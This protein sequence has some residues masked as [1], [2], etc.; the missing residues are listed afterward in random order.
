M[1]L[2]VSIAL[3][4]YNKAINYSRESVYMWQQEMK[5][6]TCREEKTEVTP[7]L[8]AEQVGSGSLPVYATPAL[9]ALWEKAAAGLLM[10]FLGKNWTSVGMEASLEHVAPSVIGAAVRAIV[11][12]EKIEGRRIDFSMEA[13]DQAGLIGRGRQVRFLVEADSFL[14]KAEHKQGTGELK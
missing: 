10:D 3:Y 7:A 6:G 5:I 4:G 9:L 8:T 13:F 2:L 11:K 14:Y 1:K 12:V